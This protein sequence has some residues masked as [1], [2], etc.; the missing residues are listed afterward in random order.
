MLF[1]TEKSLRWLF[2]QIELRGRYAIKTTQESRVRG[3]S[4]YKRSVICVPCTIAVRATD[5]RRDAWRSIGSKQRALA[6]YLRSSFSSK[7]TVA[8]YV[9]GQRGTE[10]AAAA[11]EKRRDRSKRQERGRARLF[12]SRQ[13]KKRQHNDKNLRQRVRAQRSPRFAILSPRETGCWLLRSHLRLPRPSNM[14]DRDNVSGRSRAPLAATF[15]LS[16]AIRKSSDNGANSIAPTRSTFEKKVISFP[17]VKK[18]KYYMEWEYL[19]WN[20]N[21]S[22]WINWIFY[23]WKCLHINYIS[24]KER[25]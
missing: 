18:S 2:D 16:T 5:P 15:G 10:R 12:I 4:A 19:G 7:S 25:K 6:Y 23:W 9:T 11:A 1:A 3:T 14:A 22:N 20:I 13:K 17:C 8:G 21:T 24:G